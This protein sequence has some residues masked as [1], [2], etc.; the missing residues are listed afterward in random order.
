MKKIIVSGKGGAG[1]TTVSALLLKHL[2]ENNENLN[3]L[4]IDADA[5]MT[6]PYSL[7]IELKD[8]RRSIGELELQE[9]EDIIKKF[10][11]EAL[12]K[13]RLGNQDSNA[14]FDFAFMGHHTN[15]S[16]LCGYNSSL[17]NLVEAL[18]KEDAYDLV[19]IDREA[20]LEH[21][22]R[23]VYKGVEDY[24]LMV[25]WLS[26]DY[27]SVVKRMLDVGDALGSTENRLIIINDILGNAEN[28]DIRKILNNNDIEISDYAVLPRVDS[29]SSGKEGGVLGWDSNDRVEE[30]LQYITQRLI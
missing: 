11:E 29:L 7:G 6:L 9:G 30:T 5:A 15:N 10:T 23:N 26:P 4:A 28:Q 22:T 21:L 20:G 1:K 25:S 14:S 12:Y 8:D 3:L 24:I 16:C 27:L 18:A 17:Y 13:L 19:L 2:L